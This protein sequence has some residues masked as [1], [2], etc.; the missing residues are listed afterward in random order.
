MLKKK[1][2]QLRNNH[3]GVSYQ[4]S[5]TSIHLRC[6]GISSDVGSISPKGRTDLKNLTA[7]PDWLVV[8]TQLKNISQ[9]GG[10]FPIY[11]KTKN[12]PNHQVDEIVPNW[13][14]PII[15]HTRLKYVCF[16]LVRT[17]TARGYPLAGRLENGTYTIPNNAKKKQFSNAVWCNEYATPKESNRTVKSKSTY[18]SQIVSLI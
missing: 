2:P 12:V 5:G 11:G 4:L 9:L 14:A 18:K 13:C 1:Y 15:V 17:Q 8:S 3:L 7:L 6:R 16:V 10:L